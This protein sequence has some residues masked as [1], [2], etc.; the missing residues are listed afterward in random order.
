[1]PGRTRSQCHSNKRKA[2]LESTHIAQQVALAGRETVS[3]ALW[4]SRSGDWLNNQRVS[5][6]LFEGVLK[7]KRAPWTCLACL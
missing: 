3:V 6:F 7:S 2:A 5:I 1:M 4:S